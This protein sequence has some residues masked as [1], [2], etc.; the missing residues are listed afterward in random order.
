M[1]SLLLF[2]LVAACS[3]DLPPRIISSSLV[4]DSIDAH[5]PYRI[6]SVIRDE[7]R[8]TRARVLFHAGEETIVSSPEPT[9]I[10]MTSGDGETWIAELPGLPLGTVVTW[11]V[12]AQDSADHFST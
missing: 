2:L 12:D 3:D 11:R 7:R 8:V 5:G 9:P 6:V 1:R 4:R 10:E